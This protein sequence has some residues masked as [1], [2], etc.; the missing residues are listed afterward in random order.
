MDGEFYM[1]WQFSKVSDLYEEGL[2]N[3]EIEMY[4]E[5]RKEFKIL[6]ELLIQRGYSVTLLCGTLG[7]VIPGENK[8][9]SDDLLDITYRFYQKTG[10]TVCYSYGFSEEENVIFIGFFEG[11]YKKSCYEPVI[12][13]KRHYGIKQLFLE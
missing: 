2:C 9:D 4:R 11:G 7:V 6:L 3:Y 13:A 12:E 10:I 5:L 1:L 8:I